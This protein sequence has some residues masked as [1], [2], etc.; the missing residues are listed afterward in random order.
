MG[1]NHTRSQL[2]PADVSAIVAN[3]FPDPFAKLVSGTFASIM[4]IDFGTPRRLYFSN[5]NVVV[6]GVT[7]GNLG[8]ENNARIV[9]LLTPVMEDYEDRPDAIFA[10]GFQ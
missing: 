5:P 2:N 1:G 7:T 9:D 6:N 10:N 4:S 3:G 8:T